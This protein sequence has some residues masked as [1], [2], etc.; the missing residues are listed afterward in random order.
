[1]QVPFTKVPNSAI[2]DVR[3]GAFEIAVLAV[4]LRYNPSFPSYKKIARHLRL[5]RDTIWKTL[6]NL[7]EFGYITK[8]KRNGKS[9]IYGFKTHL[10]G[11]RPV[12]QADYTSLLH[13]LPPVRQ[14]DSNKTKEIRIPN[15]GFK[16]FEDWDWEEGGMPPEVK[17]DL[18]QKGIINGESES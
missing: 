2:D 5:S 12:R 14:A 3:L 16:S 8:F 15:N 18:K 6:R 1:M 10:I 17:A 9:T 11:N 4:L 13:G 7:E